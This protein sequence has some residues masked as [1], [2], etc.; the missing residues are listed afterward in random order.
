MTLPVRRAT[1]TPERRGVLDG[2]PLA[3]FDRLDR[4]MRQLL[5]RCGTDP[6]AKPASFPPPT[7]RRPTSASG[8]R[9]S[10]ATIERKDGDA[11][12]AGRRL[13]VSGERTERERAGILRHRTRTVGHFRYEVVFPTDAGEGD[14]TASYGD[15][16]PT[17]TVPKADAEK[18]RTITIR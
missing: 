11:E 14:V 13:T 2:E 17:V 16:V 3:E 4:Q 8:S 12:P 9:S 6:S 7:W 10:R 1:S 18:P 15:G 5:E